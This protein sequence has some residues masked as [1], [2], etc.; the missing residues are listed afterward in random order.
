MNGKDGGDGNS[1]IGYGKP[2][3]HTRFKPGQS[4]NV[5]GRPRESKN[6]TTT[7]TKELNQKV[8]ISENGRRKKI[9]MREAITKQALNK[10]AGAIPPLFERCLL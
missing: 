9:T 8:T 7:M 2:P 5:K 10:A 4:G 1:S 3:M 6:L